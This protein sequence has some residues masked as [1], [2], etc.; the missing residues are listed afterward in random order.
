MSP[1]GDE[2]FSLLFWGGWG[3]LG[4]IGNLDGTFFSSFFLF[5]SRKEYR[6]QRSK[7]AAF[8][9]RKQPSLPPNYQSPHI[10]VM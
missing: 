4:T 10:V 8:F 1:N 9:S 6:K 3:V 5:R 2:F 7:G